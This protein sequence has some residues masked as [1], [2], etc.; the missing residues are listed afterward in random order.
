M[1]A[2]GKGGIK[3]DG[4]VTPLDVKAGDK[5]LIGKYSGNEVKID[6]DEQGILREDEA[7]AVIE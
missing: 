5:I 4:N 3:D 2:V 6:G 1:V 7:P